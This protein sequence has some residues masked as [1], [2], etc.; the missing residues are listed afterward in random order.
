MLS[1]G[2]QPRPI[3][4]KYVGLKVAFSRRVYRSAEKCARF[5]KT[6]I[7]FVG[8][9]YGSFLKAKGLLPKVYAIFTE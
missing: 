2:S 1:L 7:G 5:F 4:V 9:F 6:I 8:T 3:F